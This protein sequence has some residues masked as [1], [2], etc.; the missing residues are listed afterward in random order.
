MIARDKGM[1]ADLPSVI[2]VSCLYGDLRDERQGELCPVCK[3]GHLAGR[4]ICWDC[5]VKTEEGKRVLEQQE[6]TRRGDETRIDPSLM[7]W[8]LTKE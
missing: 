7:K 6:E 2:C 5:F 1:P 4:A 8:G 3:K